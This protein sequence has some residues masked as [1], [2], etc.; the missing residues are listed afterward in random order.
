MMVPRLRL[1]LL[2]CAVVSAATLGSAL[3]AEHGMG[4]VPCALCLVE[5]WPYR[6]A[7]PVAAIG[8]VLPRPW[9]RV[10]LWLCLLLMMAGVVAG[11]THVGVEAGLWPSP[12][13]QCQA[14]RLEG[15]SMADRL[16]RMPALPSM[17]CEEPTYLIPAL[18]ISMAAMN[19]VVAS[20]MTIGLAIFLLRTKRSIP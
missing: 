15:L 18:P 19:L 8:F 14:P 11:A 16:A 3:Y 5:R 20:V 2:V 17:A 9:A 1:A 4:L 7:A 6:I 10:A 12:L 13:P